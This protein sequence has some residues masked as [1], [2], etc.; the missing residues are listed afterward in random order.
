MKVMNT[1]IRGTYRIDE[2]QQSG[3]SIEGMNVRK[4]AF[5]PEPT[6]SRGIEFREWPGL[7]ESGHQANA[8]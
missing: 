4:W 1:S 8:F 7:V 3:N 2:R 5:L 6:F